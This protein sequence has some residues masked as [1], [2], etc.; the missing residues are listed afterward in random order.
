MTFPDQ[1]LAH[2]I[3]PA[4]Q[5]AQRHYG[6]HPYFTKRAWNVVQ[7]YIRHFSSPGATV[8][9]PFGGSGVTA[10]EALVLRRKAVYLDI[11]P[12]ACFLARQTAVAPVNIG[13]LGEAFGQVED[14]CRKEIEAIWKTPNQKLAS[15]PVKD[16]YPRRVCLPDN[17]D[18]KY[19]EE[20]FT[21]RMLHG[22]AKLRAAIV[23]VR[24][25]S[26]RDLLLMAFSA[27]L[28]RINR[29][30]LSAANRAESR[31]GSAIFSIYRYKVAKQPVELPL[32]PQFEQRF[33]KLIEAKKE[34]NKVIGE[35]YQEGTTAFFHQGSVTDLHPFVRPESVDYI[36]TDPP[37]GGHIA[38]LDLSTMWTAWLEM[39]VKPKDRREEVIEGGTLKNTRDDYEELLRRSLLEM[40][41]VL[42]ARGW[43]SIV[44]AHR[45]TS[46]WDA[47]VSACED[48]GFSYQNTVVQP[49][50][51]VWSMHK[52]KN[53][54]KVLSGE[55]VLNFRK[56]GRRSRASRASSD[57]DTLQIVRLC[58]ESEIMKHVGTSTEHLHHVVVP[59]LLE[60]GLLDRFSREHGDIVPILERHFVF[61]GAAKVWQLPAAA[62]L[63]GTHD[64]R[65]LAKY[66]VLRYLGKLDGQST[67]REEVLNYLRGVLGP[68]AVP[69]LDLVK[70]LLHE[71]ASSRDGIRGHGKAKSRQ[72]ELVFQD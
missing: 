3:R 64:S 47:L 15:Q 19:V 12:W 23:A 65:V 67:T 42:K 27:T 49:V 62:E 28:V 40:Q 50:G 8:L 53:P 72:G 18:A 16:W 63:A 5:E 33:R 6:S 31:G 13:A 59:V 41:R 66:Y 71:A 39:E 48:A 22:L 57:V 68:S 69:G 21:P 10:V 43:L 4:K 70:S 20:L 36:Y 60:R 52:K 7:E 44:F 25:P 58:C 32:W 51:V 45:D 17:A 46:Y 14:H 1:P 38:Y 34:T 55:L 56:A 29:T 54:L 24:N 26:A 2:A 30:F 35:F 9:D 37:Y 61:D 11:N